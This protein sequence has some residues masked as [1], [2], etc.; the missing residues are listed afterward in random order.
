MGCYNQFCIV[1]TETGIERKKNV[2]IKVWCINTEHEKEKC[3][4]TQGR[5][6][7]RQSVNY[8]A[9]NREDSSLSSCQHQQKAFRCCA[10]PVHC[11][12]YWPL[13]SGRIVPH[14]NKNQGESDNKVYVIPCNT[15]HN[16]CPPL[17]NHQSI[18]QTF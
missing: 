13:I 7:K 8:A 17:H 15:R 18:Q 11:N 3:R 6:R 16:A 2:D 14:P 12:H 10:S 9:P 5:Q 1:C 4:C